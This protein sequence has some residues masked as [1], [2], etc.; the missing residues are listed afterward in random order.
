MVTN[1]PGGND[2]DAARHPFGPRP[3]GALVAAV[4]LT[5]A[6]RVSW[7]GLTA[8]GALTY[9][10]YLIH[11]H[12]GWWVI[13]H[14]YPTVPPWVAFVLAAGFSLALAAAVHHVVERRV[15]PPL[16]R[17]VR[18]GLERV[19]VRASGRRRRAPAAGRRS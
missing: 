10:L 12:W 18:R 5:R 9:P 13:A 19:D 3:I 1:E 15:G 8:A 11:E 4:T 14:V 17:V 16:R 2:A 7:R 6:S